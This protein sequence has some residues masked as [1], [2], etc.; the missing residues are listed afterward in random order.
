MA[1]TVSAWRP[2]RPG[3]STG[4]STSAPTLPTTSGRRA[5]DSAPSTRHRPALGRARP[6]RQR[7]VVVLP[8]TVGT[9][10]PEDAP[11]AHGQLQPVERSDL[12]TPPVSVA[13][14]QRFDLDNSSQRDPP[15][16]LGDP[17]ADGGEYA[18][19]ATILTAATVGPW[20]IR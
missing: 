8:G 1:R 19:S 10:E 18:G 7:I 13:L 12:P 4:A 17:V 11:A 15:D 16:V 3:F 5:G 6:S 2:E 20:S 14:V 9:E